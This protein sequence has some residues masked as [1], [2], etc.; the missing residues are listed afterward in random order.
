MRRRPRFPLLAL[1]ALLTASACSDAPDPAMPVAS[2]VTTADGTSRLTPQP[3]LRLEPVAAGDRPVLTVRP[4][5]GHQVMRGFGASFTDSA[6]TLVHSSPRRDELMAAL[7]DRERG[8]GLGMLRQPMGSSDFSS[9]F[10]SYDD[11]PPGEH[12]WRLAK[13]NIDRDR[14]RIVP[15]LRQASALN[16]QLGIIAT[17]WSPPA[18]LKDN[19]SLLGGSLY[20]AGFSTYAQY[21]V[22]FL[23][24]YAEAGVRVDAVTPQN[25]PENTAD[26]Y[27]SARM[28]AAAQAAFIGNDLGPALAAAGLGDTEI[29]AYDHNW[30]GHGYPARVLSDEKAR[31]YVRGIAFHCYRGNAADQQKLLARHP[32]VPVH[33]TECSGTESGPRAFSDTL[34]WQAEHL[35]IDGARNQASSILTWNV[36]LDPGNGP[37]FG[38][39]GHC[40]GLATVDQRT[41][42]IG[43]N[44]EYYVLGHA[45]KFVRQGAVR[46]DV[47]NTDSNGSL[48][49]TAFRNPDGSVAVVVLNPG[50]RQTFD[51]AVHDRRATAT[52]PARSLATYLLPADVSAGQRS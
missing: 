15:L 17:P 32:D 8:I 43:Y 37:S 47:E 34:L 14:A 28:T 46:I 29:L 7:F 6:A 1:C 12:D 13:F 48:H 21:F 33:I 36:A 38:R 19:D 24:A 50:E 23:L 20:A 10:G 40:T 51:L 25:E 52:L 4:E 11:V 45:A 2:W 49:S 44:A 3:P 41:G 22:R 42:E 39:C 31:K 30:N 5:N 18:W 9:S 35:L 26:Q 27:P 16:P